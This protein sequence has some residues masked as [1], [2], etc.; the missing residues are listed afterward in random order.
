[1]TLSIVIIGD[2]ILIGQVA[3]TN[4][5]FIA[6][7]FTAMGWEVRSIRTVGDEAAAITAAITESLAEADLV[8]TTGGLGPTKDDITKRV[9]TDIFGGGM[10]MDD[11]VTENIGRIFAARGLQLNELTRLQALVPDACSV[12]QNRFGTAPVMCFTRPDGKMLV[13][14]P[15]VPFETEGMLMLEPGGVAEA[16]RRRFSPDRYFRHR[17]LMAGGISESALAERLDSFESSLA[18]GLHLAYLPQP[19]LIRLRLDGSGTDSAA[20]DAAFDTAFDTLREAVGPYMV[21]DGDAS[22]AEILIEALRSRGLT[23]AAAESCTGGNI[24]RA[25]TAVAGCS[26]VFKGSVISYANDVKTGVLGVDP[27]VIEADGAVSEATVRQMAEGAR[28]LCCADCAVATSGIA[29]PGG[30][31]PT[32]PVGTVWMAVA[33]PDG[34]VTAT[35]HR[36]PGDRSRVIERATTA[37]LLALA[38]AI[39]A[40]NP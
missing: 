39:I 12:I 4:S 10:H 27:A 26:D 1:M 32:K 17:S 8:I 14:M 18:E 3:D 28:K 37:A 33:T 22:A 38:S 6:R 40:Q 24:A 20:L 16:V 34:S 19:G 21:Y 23:M 25:I 9:L 31:T 15:G 11:D 35:L 30:A 7:T 36:F 13:A 5:R 2:E 29:G